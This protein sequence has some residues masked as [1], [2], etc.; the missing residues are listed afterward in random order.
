MNAISYLI[1]E[2]KSHRAL[3]EK[4]GSDKSL[5]STFREE[6]IHHVHMEE[7]ILYPGLLEVPELEKIVRAAWKEHNLIM[8][9][10]QEMDDET[11][12]EKI[13]E[14]KFAILKKLILLHL[15]EEE[16]KIFPLVRALASEEVLKDLGQK[17]I[18]QKIVTPTE[19][20]IYPE[21][22]GSHQLRS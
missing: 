15:D 21:V 4:I 16:E 11:L 2:H 22:P 20:I 3:L 12:S 9:L 10:I 13:W 6:L 5:F 1:E 7:V 18:V 17:M 19:D 8:G 14:S